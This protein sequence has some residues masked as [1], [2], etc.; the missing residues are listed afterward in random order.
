MSKEMNFFE[1]CKLVKSTEEFNIEFIND[2][3]GTLFYSCGFEINYTVNDLDIR[4]PFDFFPLFDG[5]ADNWEEA[6]EI[7]L[8]FVN[9][10]LRECVDRDMDEAVYKLVKEKWI[11]CMN[12]IITQIESIAEAEHFDLDSAFIKEDDDEF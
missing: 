1:V 2:F 9:T 7:M 6:K 3:S 4:I 12:Y 10:D 8:D 11:K 5:N